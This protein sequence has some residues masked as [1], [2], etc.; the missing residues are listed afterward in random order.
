[1]LVIIVDELGQVQELVHLE[2]TVPEYHQLRQRLIQAV[3]D[4]HT[5]V[6][7]IDRQRWPAMARPHATLDV[8]TTRHFV[9]R[10]A[11]NVGVG[12]GDG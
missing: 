3:V 10:Q 11:S 9:A 1:M 4:A 8:L 2:R 7:R 6:A 12:V 5:L